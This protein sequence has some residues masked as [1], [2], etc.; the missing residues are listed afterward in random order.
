VPLFALLAP[1]AL[2]IWLEDRFALAPAA[3]AF[4]TAL[5][6]ALFALGARGAVARTG[7]TLLGVGL[8]AL[9][10]ALRL[11]AP[12]PETEPGPV[13][14]TLLESP[15]AAHGA[16][17]A[18]I[19]VHGARPG[20]ALLL[21]RGD[22]CELLPGATALARVR[23]ESLRPPSNPGAG[24]SRRRLARRGIQRIAR[25]HEEAWTPIGAE[26]GGAAAGI[27]RLR[28]RFASR[29]D[30]ELAPTR[31]GA[32]L[33][34]I[35]V[36]DV[37][38]LDERLRRA[39]A[40]SGT[41][42]LLSVSGTHIVWVFW[43]TRI[44]V[45]FALGRSRALPLVRAARG[46]GTLA[47]AAAGLAYAFLCGLEAP[48]LRSAAMAAAGG[49]ALVGG[50]PGAAWNALALAALAVLAFDPGAL[51][52]AS[53]QMSFAAVAGLLV[54][55]PPPGALR[56]LAHAS[57]GA[58]LATAPLAAN[59]G[60]SLPVGW[61]VA[62]ALAVP[63]FG[64]AVVPPALVA[65]ALGDEV[66]ALARIAR[67]LAELGIR[68][69]ESLA[70]ADLLAGPRDRVAVAA[71]LAALAFAARGLALRRRAL[72]FA[73]GAGAVVSFA[74]AWPTENTRVETPEL[75]FLDVGHGDAVLVRASRRAWLVDAGTRAPDFDAGHSVVLPALR[76]LGVRRLDAL[77]LTH[78]D[79]DHVGGAAAVL[80]SM[81]V[82]ELGLTR[83]TLAAAALR[84][85]RRAAARRGV[86]VR[87][88]A[89]GDSLG[90]GGL[91]LLALWPEPA[92]RPP[93]TNAGSLV[94]RAASARSCALLSGD[95]P[96]AVE[97]ALAPVLGR[98][99]VLKLGHHGSATSSDPGFL[100]ALDPVV[101]V[102]SA[103]RR[104]RAPL[105]HPEVR[106]RL[107]A[108]SIS[109]FE[110]RRDGALRIELDRPGPVV[111]PWL[112]RR[113]AD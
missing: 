106:A 84:Q 94:L 57:L 89:A 101:A 104:P 6:C 93:T 62:N 21:G 27:E 68:M 50:R 5:G 102:A 15:R 10:L 16:C 112:T 69:L 41:T 13:A 38:R 48:A 22:L 32:L 28:R 98:C 66:P 25:L 87:I 78:A 97:R 3:C 63:Y 64:V 80:E 23:L 86:A 109:L 103:G 83:E 17:R 74:L 11:H 36:A 100:A 85:V 30:P 1:F 49:L 7:E 92:L 4:G 52:E 99:D 90:A 110:T 107:R 31:A 56:G 8:G 111:R 42:H 81:P 14:I 33:R 44:C 45:A 71:L 73:A 9:A 113:W 29:L 77:A 75:A 54:W 61:L 95:A 51:F 46:A 24:D 60:A 55:R 37:S 96:A 70:S 108:R 19:W 40:D 79:L 34:A 105:P 18:A 53:F 76:A 88:V 26:P 59:L 43:L 58:G 91:E 82:A 2:G 65:G 35:A 72:T 67:A 47:G 20:R 39:F 12:I